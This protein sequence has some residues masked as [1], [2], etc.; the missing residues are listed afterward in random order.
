ML[1]EFVTARRHQLIARTRE[2]VASRSAPRAT[3]RELETGVPLFLDQ[4]AAALHDARPTPGDLQAIGDTA[5]IHGGHLLGQGFTVSQV[6]HGY[7]D[8]CQALT[9]LAQ[10]TGAAITVE[11]FHTLNG[12]L[13]DAIAQAVTEYARLQEKAINDQGTMRSGVLAHE[14]RNCLSAASM[15]FELVKRGTVAAGGSVSGLISRN[16]ARMGVLIHRSMTEVRLSSGIEQRERVLLADLI[17]EAEVDGALDA[18]A[19]KLAFTVASV[20]RSVGLNVD[21]LILAGA[22]ANLLQNAFKFTRPGGH[23]T[24]RTSATAQ[25]VQIEVEDECGGLSSGMAE[26]VFQAFQQRGQDRSGL[27]LGLFISSRGVKA[28]GGLLRVR[29]LPGHGCIFTIDLP[30]MS[31]AEVSAGHEPGGSFDGS[32]Q[33]AGRERLR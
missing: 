10:E 21:R 28:N 23:V 4:L 3:A 5:A 29:D 17:E 24:L 11:E 27:G 18:T 9:E 1:H 16:L 33:G 20:D 22:I 7:G 15:G 31:A 32:E 13:D 12:C 2:K 14:L 25:R 26:K 6:V 19:R 8:V 30:R